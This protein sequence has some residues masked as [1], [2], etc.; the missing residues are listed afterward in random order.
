MARGRKAGSTTET[1]E[2]QIEKA[3]ERV[4][5]TKQAYDN[6][7]DSLQKLLDKRD[8]Q[9]KDNL[10]AAIVN[11]EKTYDEILKF[12]MSGSKIEEE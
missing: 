7:V 6:A 1:I 12:I 2:Q 5:K 9:R 10:W 8:A 3:Q 4:I 11:S